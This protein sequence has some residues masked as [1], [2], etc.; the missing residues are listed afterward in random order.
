MSVWNLRRQRIA[1]AA[2]ESHFDDGARYFS[3]LSTEAGELRR[4]DFCTAC[5]TARTADQADLFWWRTRHAERQ[6]RG[7]SFNI[8]TIEALFVALEGRNDL[9]VKE[10]RFL[11]CLLLMRKR[12]VKIVRMTQESGGEAFVVRR[13]RREEAL[14]VYV[15]DFSPERMA[16]LREELRALFASDD[17]PLELAA[18][19]QPPQL[20]LEET[21]DRC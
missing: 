10:L 6:R 4:R 16:E 11:L 9:R 19:I 8:E 5:W 20:V 2:C 17:A 3:L 18:G 14:V 1:C 15:Y 12:R 13:P 7:V 21:P